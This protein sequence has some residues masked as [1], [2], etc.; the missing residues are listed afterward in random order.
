[1]IKVKKLD[2]PMILAKKHK[3]WTSELLNHIKKGNPIPKDLGKKYRLLSIKKQVISE[4]QGKCIY[5]ESQLCLVDFDK[6]GKLKDFS[7]ITS[8]GDVEH[9]LPKS[10]FHN[11]TFD[12]KNL[13]F[14]CSV[15]NVS[16]LDY[17]D[18]TYP[19]IDPYVD[20]PEDHLFTIGPIL[21][22][23]IHSRRGK[24]TIKEIQLN[25]KGLIEARQNALDALSR[26]IELYALEKHPFYKEQYRLNILEH[27]KDY[28]EFLSCKKIFLGLHGLGDLLK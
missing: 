10:K 19:L 2:Q 14:V 25:R 15:C 21:S 13:G 9:I 5:C 24:A 7:P 12:W 8:F 26:D 3:D 17:Y 4:S 6:K 27:F 28:K 22:P 1:M 20:N 11:L 23:K 16:K 18:S